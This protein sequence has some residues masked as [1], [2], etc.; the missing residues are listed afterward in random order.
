MELESCKD[1]R[2][3]LAG[4]R[5]QVGRDARGV[6]TD[7]VEGMVDELSSKG[8]QFEQYDMDPIKA[9]EKGIADIGGELIAWFKDPDGN[10][11]AVGPP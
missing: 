11:L 3:S 10:T 2:L 9:N 5:R 6:G 7:D 1:P 8:V 4:E